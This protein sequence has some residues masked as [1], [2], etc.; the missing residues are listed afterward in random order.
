MAEIRCCEKCG[1]EF[2]VPYPSS[3]KRFCSH[4]C[5]NQWK[6]EN[7]RNRKEYLATNCAYCSKEILI[8]L[9]DHRV[10]EGQKKFFCSKECSFE[11]IRANPKIANCV[12][13]GKPFKKDHRKKLCS[14]ECATTYRKYLSYKRLYDNDISLDD[15]IVLSADVNVFSFAG[16]ESQ[17]LTEYRQKNRLRLNKQRREKVLGNEVLQYANRVKKNIQQAYRRN[18]E[19]KEPTLLILGCTI[20][21]FSKHIESLFVQGM[22]KENYGEWE[23]D[24]IVPISS[25]KTKED[26]VRLCHYTNY[27][28][29]WK[30]DNLRKK[31]NHKV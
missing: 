30:I 16:R 20:D 31:N 27:Q 11:H 23:L 18:S 12:V 10:R 1:R 25:A 7:I 24:H 6:W 15:F 3:R 13:C 21:E 26:V 2:A 19:L 5:S 17:Y 8:P 29:L 14:S 4:K 28:P 22:S 9:S